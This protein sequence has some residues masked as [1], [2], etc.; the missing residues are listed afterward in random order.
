MNARISCLV[1]NKEW[2]EGL[3]LSYQPKSSKHL[4]E[5]RSTGEKK[6]LCMTK[7]A[8]YII[9][10]PTANNS[11]G[12]AEVKEMDSVDQEG[13]VNDVSLNPTVD[14]MSNEFEIM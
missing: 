12:N 2:H 11:Q 6:S 10:R 4:I 13:Q 5:F 1:D 14:L 3:V 9:E 8:F 7:V